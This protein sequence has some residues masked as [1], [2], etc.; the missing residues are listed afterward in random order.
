MSKKVKWLFWG[1]VI[2]LAGIAVT[3]AVA[4]VAD[5]IMSR[6]DTKVYFSE[7]PFDTL[8]L[9]GAEY[10]SCEIHT[11][12]GEYKIEA[13]IKAWRP[14]HIDLDKRLDMSTKDGQ[15]GIVFEPFPNDFFGMF[16]QPYE[17]IITVYSPLGDDLDIR[18]E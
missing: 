1:L 4:I 7:K 3:M 18:W 16:A 5:M 13:Y 2:G 6:E 14:E 9:S 11:A 12:Q 17:M 15:L 8:V 10:S